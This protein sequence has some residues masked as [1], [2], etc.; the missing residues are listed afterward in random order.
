MDFALFLLLML[1]HFSNWRDLE[2]DPGELMSYQKKNNVIVSQ[3]LNI[4]LCY[5]PFVR[6]STV[7]VNVKALFLALQVPERSFY[8]DLQCEG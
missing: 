3:W 7:Q 8:F 2:K 1:I 4:Y 6:Y 5:K